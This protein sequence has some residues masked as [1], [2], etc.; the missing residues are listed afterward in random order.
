MKKVVCLLCASF[1]AAFA[2][3]ST[4]R[5]RNDA[6]YWW[7]WDHGRGD[8]LGARTVLE[9]KGVDVFG[10]YRAEV[11][12]NTTGGL[13]RGAVYTGLVDFG[14]NVDLEKLVSWKGASVSTTWLWLSG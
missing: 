13:R 4:E 11:W 1:S 10:G 3:S 8:W 5:V 6:D 14:A 9:D 12:G 7:Q 2:E